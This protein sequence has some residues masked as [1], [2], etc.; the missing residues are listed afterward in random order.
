ME[1]CGVLEIFGYIEDAEALRRVARSAEWND[2]GLD[3]NARS[4]ES[5]IIEAI[6]EASESGTWIRLMKDECDTFEE[7][8]MACQAAGLSYIHSRGVSGGEGYD[9]ASYWTRG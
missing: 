8:R 2:L 4:S 1:E 5:E 7:T 6:V 9:T 3:W